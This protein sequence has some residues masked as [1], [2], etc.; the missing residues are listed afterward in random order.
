[1][2]VW[3]SPL[4]CGEVVPALAGV[5][6]VVSVATVG[7]LDEAAAVGVEVVGAGAGAVVDEVLV[8]EVVVEEVEP[9]E[10]EPEPEPEPAGAVCE[11]LSTSCRSWPLVCCCVSVCVPRD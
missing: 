4:A 5:T 11:S 10:P 1:M 3:A 6:A 9:V 2:P 7:V 8:D